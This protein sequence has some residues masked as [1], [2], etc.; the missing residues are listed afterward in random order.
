MEREA[1][2]EGAIREAEWSLRDV[3]LSVPTGANDK[4]PYPAAL[5]RWLAAVE[6]HLALLRAVQ[7][8]QGGS[9]A[10]DTDR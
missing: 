10:G 6:Q 4:G 7:S 3:R 2:M 1:K 9:G 8:A 5:E